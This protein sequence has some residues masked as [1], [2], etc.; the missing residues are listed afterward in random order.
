M[1][2][3]PLFFQADGGI[4][5]GHVT[6][7]QTCAL[8]IFC[9]RA[10]LGSSVKTLAPETLEGAS[11][12]T[13]WA[14]A[15]PASIWARFSDHTRTFRSEERRVGKEGRKRESRES[16]KKWRDTDARLPCLVQRR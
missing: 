10:L 6:G 5:D 13:T 12:D 3:S 1:P 11:K 4:R 8:P 7:V 9:A 2:P 15:L 16:F 14:V